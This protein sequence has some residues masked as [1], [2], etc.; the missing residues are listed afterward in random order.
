MNNK[1]YPIIQDSEYAT[2]TEILVPTHDGVG[3]YTR[4][5]VP[6]GKNKC[7][8][9]FDR[10]PYAETLLGRPYD[11]NKLK[12]NLFIKRGYAIVTQ[13]CR[14]TANSEGEMHPYE[15]ERADGLLALEYIRTLPF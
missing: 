13:H 12:D 10:T 7:P 14:G 15:N 2:V 9:V 11:I 3:I 4:I 1:T 8:I 5:A 6:K